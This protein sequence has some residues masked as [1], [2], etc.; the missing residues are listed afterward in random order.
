VGGR[1]PLHRGLDRPGP[2]AAQRRLNPVGYHSRV[3]S[4][5]L[6]EDGRLRWQLWAKAG[7]RSRSDPWW[8]HGTITL[9]PRD[10][11]FGPRQYAYDTVGEPVTATVRMPHGDDHEVTLTLQR[12]TFGRRTRRRFHSWTVDWSSSHGI[13]QGLRGR[14][15]HGSAV[16]VTAESVT[17]GAWPAEA[18]ARVALTLTEDRTRYG[19]QPPASDAA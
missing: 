7:E 16:T 18:T 4:L 5:S 17:A 14:T 13:P 3:T 2:A 19:F 11:L 15:V 1:R 6:H 8:Q 10:R 9:D 12:C